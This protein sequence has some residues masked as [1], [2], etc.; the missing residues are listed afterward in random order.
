MGQ[1]RGQN[2]D[3]RGFKAY[4]HVK[5]EQVLGYAVRDQSGMVLSRQQ[6]NIGTLVRKSS[7]E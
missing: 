3:R 2:F 5:S 1:K 7:Q 6:K 4:R